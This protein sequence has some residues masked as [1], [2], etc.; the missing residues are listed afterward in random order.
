M[1]LSPAST[2][3]NITI[4][5]NTQV[6]LT[7]GTYN[8]NSLN[9]SGGGSSLYLPLSLSSPVI[10]NIAGSGIATTVL[11]LSGNSL[12]NNTGIAAN[13]Q[14]VYAGTATITLAGGANSYGVVYA[15][16]AAINTSGGAAWYGAV[17]S[18]TFTDSGGAPVHFD[19]ALLNS[20]LQVGSFS[21]I[22]FSWSKF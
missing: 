9:L 17:V 2:Y 8:I 22:N 21:P 19:A 14:V 3:G 10:L 12:S 11:S 16:N 1:S 20:L 4:S 7:A 15:P 6:D 18:K 13:F 5:G